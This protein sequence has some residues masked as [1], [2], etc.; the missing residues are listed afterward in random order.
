M[1]NY[2]IEIALQMDKGYPRIDPI[3]LILL[4]IMLQNKTLEIFLLLLSM[5]YIRAK[6]QNFICGMK[7]TFE[8]FCAIV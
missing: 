2:R 3:C 4:G 1:I 8:A 5:N 7:M 6:I